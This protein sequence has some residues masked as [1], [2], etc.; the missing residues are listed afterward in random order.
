MEKRLVGRVALVTGGATGIGAA[1]VER[2]AAEGA[3]VA[4]C[5]NKSAAGAEALVARLT[6]AGYV[7][8]AV[9]MDVTDGQAVQAGIQAAVDHFGAPITI[10]AGLNEDDFEM[11]RRLVEERLKKLYD[12]TDLIWT[13]PEKIKKI[14]KGRKNRL[15]SQKFP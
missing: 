7:V 11:K 10:P 13:D 6:E 3:R 2:L 12:D 8:Y 9:R 5:Y 4:C 15:T 1:T 14:F